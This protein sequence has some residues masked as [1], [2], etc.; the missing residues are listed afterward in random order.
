MTK[1]CVSPTK[2][3]DSML[4]VLCDTNPMVLNVLIDRF[5]IETILLTDSKET[6]ERITSIA[7][8]I[9]QNLSKVFMV[10]N[11]IL[12]EFYPQPRYRVYSRKCSTASYL[13]INIK[14]RMKFVQ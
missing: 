8:N 4:Q 12:L 14:Q 11:G 2:G 5:A 9:P 6:A 1:G 10:L 3:T 7:E 13:Q